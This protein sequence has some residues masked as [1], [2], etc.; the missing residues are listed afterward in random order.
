MSDDL[1]RP[2]VLDHY[3]HPR[4]WGRLERPDIVADADDPSCGDQ[5]HIEIALDAEGRVGRVA[6][7]GE[8]CIVSMASASI[9][10]ERIKGRSLAELR[11]ISEDDVL[12]WFDVPVGRARRRCALLPLQVLRAALKAYQ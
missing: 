2:H 9:F 3:A 1:Y 6:F 8:G 5:V 4:N 11:A 12:A 7:E 10:T